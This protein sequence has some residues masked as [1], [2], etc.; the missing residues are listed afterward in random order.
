MARITILILI[1]MFPLVLQAQ[2]FRCESP[3][4]PVYSQIPC[5][6]NA[7]RLAKYDPAVRVD[8]KPDPDSEEQD[9]AAEKQLSPMENFVTTLQNQRQQQVGDIDSNI[10]LLKKQLGA[11]GESAIEENERKFLESD[12]ARLETERSSIVEQYARLISEAESRA[13]PAG[14]TKQY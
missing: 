9:D 14:T 13:G 5:D 1:F 3:N 11:T 7:E 8:D 2:V 12:L 10:S 4:G 6:E